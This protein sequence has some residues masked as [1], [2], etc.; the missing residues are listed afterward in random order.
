MSRKTGILSLF[1][2]DF[3]LKLFIEGTIIG[4]FVGAL[5]VAFRLILEKA[6][7]LRGQIYVLLRMDGFGPT[8]LWFLGLI[9]IGLILAYIIKKVPMSGGSGIPQVKGI[10]LG[11]FKSNPLA[12][13]AGKFIGGVLGIGAGLSLG[14][15]GPSI[16]LGA[17]VSQFISSFLGRLKIEEKY[18]I[19][20]GA[21]AGL[22]A[23]FSAPLAGVVFSLEELHKNFSP[24]VLISSMAA[25]LSADVV[26]QNV[27]GQQPIFD[28]KNLVVFPLEYSF[29]LIGLG[30]ICGLLGVVFNKSL[31]KTLGL[32]EKSKLPKVLYPVI[33]LLIA[34]I[35]GFLLPEVLGGGND[36]VESLGV[37]DYSLITV[38]VFLLVK[39]IFTMLSYGS[40][41]PGG[42]F[43]P[44]LVLG[45]LT[46]DIYSKVIVNNLY[47][48]PV[49]I[50]NFVIYAMAA[51]FT[52]IVKAPVT[53]S[54][55]ITE[56]TGSFQHLFPLI[57]VS[58]IAYI[59]SD[60]LKSKSVYDLLY[61]RSVNQEKID[62]SKKET[63]EMVIHE[64]VVCIGSK[65]VGKRIKDIRW[66][67]KCLL[68]SIKRGDINIIPNG[69]T[70]IMAGDYLHALVQEG[71][72]RI[73]EKLSFLTGEYI[74]LNQKNTGFY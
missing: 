15:E 66:P 74:Y 60:I 19:T 28:F 4:I 8:L 42:I 40:G 23:A 22:A 63:S 25:A 6:E 9:C 30:I 21:S 11:Q 56:M 55:L 12:L 44:L 39:F 35:L 37:I 26:A 27:F 13:I 5:I 59:V 47:L 67:K 50:H 51:Y 49:Y 10:L 38:M 32:Y 14:R 61:D 41:V 31:I 2:Q 54:I 53:G 52:A 68:V 72:L 1:R 69:E 7:E 29:Y 45:S 16:Q 73:Y 24:A 3:R 33:P 65:L 64:F 70:I 34:G 57:F 62:S 36:L 20:C 71:N 43:L 58:M 46:G 48:D 17:A 18:L